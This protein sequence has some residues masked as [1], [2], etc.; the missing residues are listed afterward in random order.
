MSPCLAGKRIA[1]SNTAAI[2]FNISLAKGLLLWINGLICMGHIISKDGD[3]NS[4]ILNRRGS[5]IGRA[6]NAI[7]WFGK[8][9]CQVKTKLLKSILLS[10]LACHSIICLSPARPSVRHT[11]GSVKIKNG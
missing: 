4:D 2:S 9:A 8:L 6:N 10:V 7:Y 3:D 1:H 11:G 5:F